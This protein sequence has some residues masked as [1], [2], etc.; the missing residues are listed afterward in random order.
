MNE[1]TIRQIKDITLN[2]MSINRP[3]L[4]VDTKD[5]LS[6]FV[7]YSM[8]LQIGFI[9]GQLPEAEWDEFINSNI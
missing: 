8:G 1:L 3:D 7:D 4:S 9:I 6:C 5:G 2:Y